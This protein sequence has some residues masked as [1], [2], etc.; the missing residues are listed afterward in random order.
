MNRRKH[1]SAE[2][3]IT[4][5]I[6]VLFMLIIFFVLTTSFIHGKL[7]VDL[8]SEHS[9][10]AETPKAITVTVERNGAIYWD[11]VPVSKHD[12]P[13]LV[14]NTKDNNILV[15]G[16]KNVSYGSVIELL[17]LLRESG[18]TGAGLLIGDTNKKR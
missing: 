14:T 5:L 10:L 18:V 6:D 1:C 15:A 8:P 4:P 16:D 12:I 9:L 3:D 11:G 2:L 7:E 17:S 13:M